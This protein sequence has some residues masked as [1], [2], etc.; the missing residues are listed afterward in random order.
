MIGLILRGFGWL[1]VALAVVG[2]GIGGGL[3][4]Y[5]HESLAGPVAAD[6]GD[7]ITSNHVSAIKSPNQPAIALVAGYDV[8]GKTSRR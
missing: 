1:V 4:L 5:T 2:T 7:E 3:Y 6:Q 8:R